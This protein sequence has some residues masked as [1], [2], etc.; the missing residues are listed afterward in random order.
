M[1]LLLCGAG[2]PPVDQALPDHVAYLTFDD[3]PGPFTEA[4]LDTLRDEQ[5][6]ASFFVNAGNGRP[7]G[8]LLA[9]GATLRRI[10]AEGHVLGNHT[11]DHSD[12]T[13]LSL[14]DAARELDDNDR[15]IGEA[16]GQP[17][18]RMLALRPPYGFVDERVQ[19]VL[20]ARG[21]SFVW[22]LNSRDANDWAPG[23]RPDGRGPPTAAYRAKVAR[24]PHVIADS[25]LVREGKGV[26]ILLHDIHPTT[27]DALPAI[28]AALRERGYGFASLAAF[29]P[30]SRPDPAAAEGWVALHDGDA[31][32]VAGDVEIET[33]ATLALDDIVIPAPARLVKH[34]RR[35][36]YRVH[37]PEGQTAR[38]RRVEP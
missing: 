6:P 8:S 2:V 1:S 20:A 30:E 3:G 10:V 26:I 5:V 9:H 12:L 4:V 22:N 15:L 38:M 33:A 31:V 24:M 21:V 23:E 25:R 17:N 35:A 11:V 18:L 29:L 16:L 14:V 32:T 19:P 34:L 7:A 13:K 37:L 28:I 36:R 27:R